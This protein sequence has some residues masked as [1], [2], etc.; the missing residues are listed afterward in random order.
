MIDYKV[1]NQMSI[2]ASKRI[3]VHLQQVNAYILINLSAFIPSI[4]S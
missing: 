3:G 1:P 2:E 4:K